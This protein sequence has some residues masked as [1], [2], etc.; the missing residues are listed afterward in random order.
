MQ[1]A[2]SQALHER[3]AATVEPALADAPS[4]V[5]A[6]PARRRRAAKMK[7]RPHLLRLEGRLR[8]L[9]PTDD[10][11]CRALLV[12]AM[13]LQRASRGHHL[14]RQVHLLLLVGR[15][16][17]RLLCHS[18]LPWSMLAGCSVKGCCRCAPPPRP[19]VCRHQAAALHAA[20][21]HRHGQGDTGVG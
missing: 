2:G 18:V 5:F 16:L 3:A 17:G 19:A 10:A 12:A 4:F 11:S 21:A 7:G 1:S 15:A 14:T 6:L 9:V 8:S 13:A 20:A